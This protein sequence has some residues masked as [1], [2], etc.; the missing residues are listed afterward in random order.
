MKTTDL[1]AGPYKPPRV[2]IGD[3]LY[4]ERYGKVVVSAFS[5]RLRWPCCRP[6]GSHDSLIL[7]GELV[8]AVETESVLAISYWWTVCDATV[9]RWRRCL[10]VGRTNPGTRRLRGQQAKQVFTAERRARAIKTI[11]GR[12]NRQKHSK[13]MLKRW[14]TNGTMGNY[15]KWQ[16]NEIALLGKASDEA[17]A[18][19]IG[20]SVFAVKRERQALKI[21]MFYT[22]RH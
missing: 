19:T 16:P 6:K 17:V 9:H 21:P 1:I 18:K 11:K 15:K 4:C 2:R 5:G 20:R 7:C 22:I 10:G 14:N 3:L 13:I 8:R 12:K